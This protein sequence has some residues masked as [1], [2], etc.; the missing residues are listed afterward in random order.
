[1]IRIFQSILVFGSECG[2]VSVFLIPTDIRK[3][4]PKLVESFKVGAKRVLD[5]VLIRGEEG[6]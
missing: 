1:M 3:Q 5:C 6:E 2:T 4:S